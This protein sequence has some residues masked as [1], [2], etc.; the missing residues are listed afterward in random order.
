VQLKKT[1]T[2]AIAPKSA[3]P[4]HFTTSPLLNKQNKQKAGIK[5]EEISDEWE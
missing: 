4:L 2:T 3:I 5:E 1:N